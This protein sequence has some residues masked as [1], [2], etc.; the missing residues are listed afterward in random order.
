VRPSPSYQPF[1]LESGLGTPERQNDTDFRTV[2]AKEQDFGLIVQIHE[3]LFDTRALSGN[4]KVQN[5]LPHRCRSASYQESK[6]RP[7][8]SVFFEAQPGV[9]AQ[10]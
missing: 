5:T 9:S 1:P 7:Y 2:G 8:V 4:Q 6:F 10:S 3:T